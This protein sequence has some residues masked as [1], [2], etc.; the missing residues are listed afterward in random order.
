MKKIKVKT[1]EE[2]LASQENHEL[3][4]TCISISKGTKVYLQNLD[5]LGEEAKQTI[6]NRFIENK[7]YL[8][9]IHEKNYVYDCVLY[10]DL[11]TKNT[12]DYL[13]STHMLFNIIPFLVD[14]KLRVREIYID[15]H[16]DS[17]RPMQVLAMKRARSSSRLSYMNMENIWE[18]N[19]GSLLVKSGK[20]KVSF[21]INKN[22]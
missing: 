10:L 7:K 8:S 15:D 12:D 22:Y 3:A 6:L 2:I 5:V 1:F 4:E 20:C 19:K 21:K 17:N 13:V 16:F 11:M 14:K 18:A 9:M